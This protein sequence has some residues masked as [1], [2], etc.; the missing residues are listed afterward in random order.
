[1]NHRLAFAACVLMPLAA[2]A[3]SAAPVAESNIRTEIAIDAPMHFAQGPGSFDVFVDGDLAAID[4]GG[5]ERL[6]KGAPYCA[7]ALHETVQTLLDASGAV[8]NRIVRTTKTRLCRDGEGRTRQEIERGGRKQVILRDPVARESWVLD[9]ERKSARRIG[10]MA[11][12]G[13]GSTMNLLESS[14]WHDYAERVREWARSLA[15]RARV[16]PKPGTTAPVAPVA[17]AAPTPPLPPMVAPSAM[18][19]TEMVVITRQARDAAENTQRD[20]EVRLLRLQEPGAGVAPLPPTPSPVTWTARNFAP[21]GEGVLTSL[22]SKEIEGLKVN[23][24]RTTW[25]I[26]AGKVGNEKPIQIVRDVWTSPELMLT[27]QSRDF[28]PRRGETSYRLANVRRG[29]PDAALMK[30]PAD[31]SKPAARAGSAP[32]A[33]G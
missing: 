12:A 25:T 19:E 4:G 1:M 24:E 23:G 14:G 27:V 29:E 22:G 2:V 18:A 32:A 26:E 9:V 31:Y 20:A 17:P 8:G 13:S 33:R 7:D 28:D 16:S 30:V 5:S 21:R 11:F 15:D 6:V 10:T 3:Q